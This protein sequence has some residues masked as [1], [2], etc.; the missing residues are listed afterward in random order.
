MTGNT[1]KKVF[2]GNFSFSVDDEKLR[3]FFSGVGTVVMAKVVM[4]GGRSRGFGFVEMATPEEA[5][6]A[7]EKL[8]GTEWEGRIIKV[9]PDR[10]AQRSRPG[11][12][13]NREG[14]REDRG[15]SGGEGREGRGEGYQPLRPAYFRAQ[16]LDMS[17]RRRRKIDPFIEDPKLAVD[18]K[19][20][21]LLRRFMSER[22]R[23]LSRRMTGLTA[24]HQRQVSRAIKRAQHLALL[25]YTDH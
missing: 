12:F 13:Y 19:D 18:Y 6:T 21:R 16:P 17:Q 22:G 1:M 11:G 15:T 5:Q 25:P 24:A 2:V 14:G 10:G 23:I 3:E 9:N 7:I 20:P 4:E 8:D